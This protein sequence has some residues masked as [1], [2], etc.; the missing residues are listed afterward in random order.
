[1]C[2]L[3]DWGSCSL[4]KKM[5][6]SIPMKSE[7]RPVETISRGRLPATFRRRVAR[8]V[9]NTCNKGVNQILWNTIFREVLSIIDKILCAAK[10]Y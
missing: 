10:F 5:V 6:P 8:L 2:C 7:Q 4:R 9:P 3:P 1:M